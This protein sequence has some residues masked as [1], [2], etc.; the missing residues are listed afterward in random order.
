MKADI[1]NKKSNCCVLPE[2][3]LGKFLTLTLSLH[4]AAFGMNIGKVTEDKMLSCDLSL[5]YLHRQVIAKLFFFSL[6]LLEWQELTLLKWHR[7]L[8]RCSS[9]WPVKW[10][11]WW[12]ICL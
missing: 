6:P 7:L 8:L 10:K 11:V 12:S 3:C 5:S 2:T 9:T 1:A 4:L